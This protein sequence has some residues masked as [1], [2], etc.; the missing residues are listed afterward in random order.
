M[1]VNTYVDREHNM[2]VQKIEGDLGASEIIAA[3]KRLYVDLEFDPK[4]P[5]L[6]DASN[7][8]VAGAVSAEQMRA[9]AAESQ[10]LWKK[11]AGGK[12]AI[13]VGRESDYGMGRMY[14]MLADRMPRQ[15][16]VFRSRR[17]AIEWL[18][19]ED[20]PGSGGAAKE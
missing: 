5:C 1:P 17:E 4:R 15:L 7:G 2:A 10:V 18:T 9:S 20:G 12:T 6:W 13:L 8:R 16:R 11:M 14:E 3:Q 19:L